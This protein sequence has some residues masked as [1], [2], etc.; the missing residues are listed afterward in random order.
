VPAEW[1]TNPALVKGKEEWFKE[2]FSSSLAYKNHCHIHWHIGILA[3][4]QIAPGTAFV[5]LRV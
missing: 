1:E 2:T 5:N 3:H 4:F